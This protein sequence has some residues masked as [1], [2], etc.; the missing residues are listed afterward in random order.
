MEDVEA[1]GLDAALGMLRR[2]LCFGE[3]HGATK[4]RFFNEGLARNFSV[5]SCRS[6]RSQP[7][8]RLAAVRLTALERATAPSLRRRSIRRDP[9]QIRWARTAGHEF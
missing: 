8:Y 4:S 9:Q 5:R 3:I 7:F 2:R 6:I 1:G